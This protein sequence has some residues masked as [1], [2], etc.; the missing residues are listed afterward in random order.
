MNQYATYAPENNARVI[1]K[2]RI[3]YVLSALAKAKQQRPSRAKKLIIDFAKTCS[4]IPNELLHR[5]KIDSGFYLGKT[6]SL[7]MTFHVAK[8]ID[9]DGHISVVGGSGSGKSSCHSRPTLESCTT[10]FVALDINGELYEHWQQIDR[11]N[12]RSAKVIN[13]T[14]DIG[15]FS[16]YDP[17]YNLGDFNSEDYVQNLRE[18]VQ[19]LVPLPSNAREPFFIEAAQNVVSGLIAYYHHQGN[20]FNEAV[21]CIQGILLSEQINGVANGDCELANLMLA[22]YMGV[23]K[24][25]ESK[26]ILSIATTIVTRLIAFATDPVVRAAL[27]P[28]GNTVRW[29]DIE[30]HNIFIRVDQSKLEQWGPV[31]TLILTQFIRKLERRPNRHTPAGK[32]MQPVLIMLDE[33]PRIGKMPAIA[34]ALATLRIKKVTI[35]LFF[36]SISQLDGLY[37]EDQRR[38]IL[39]NCPYLSVLTVT[40]PDTQKHLSDR[41]GIRKASKIVTKGA[42]GIEPVALPQEFG[43]PSYINIITPDGFYRIIKS[44]Y[45]GEPKKRIFTRIIDYFKNLFRNCPTLKVFILM[46]ITMLFKK[47]LTNW[48]LSILKKLL[49]KYLPKFMFINQL[50]I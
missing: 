19:C 24:L 3:K 4:D 7:G 44:P 13:L 46:K 1:N 29:E 5:E 32:A 25:E 8:P 15:N 49:G 43:N 47:P 14:S 33:F 26:M 18:L 10:P 20:T 37:G 50:F 35:A 9:I 48:T 36:Q 39:E 22:Q 34:N 6:K 30:T 45:Y 21:L 40:D 23:S 2:T 12:K 41:A 28:S 16:T 42:D 17:M 27:E 31:I 38:S 11:P